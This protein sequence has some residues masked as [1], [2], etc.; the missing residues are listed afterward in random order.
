MAQSAVKDQTVYLGA[1]QISS[2]PGNFIEI[3]KKPL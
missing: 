3:D 2:K 1:A